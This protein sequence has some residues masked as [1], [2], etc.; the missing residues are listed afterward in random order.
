VSTRWDGPRTRQVGLL[1][2]AVAW[3]AWSCTTIAGLDGDYQLGSGV[4]GSAQAVGGAN[5]RASSGGASST[6]SDTGGESRGS[7]G[8]GGSG[9][10]GGMNPPVCGDG[11]I[12]P[13]EECDD[14]PSS[15]SQYCDACDVI[16]DGP[17]EVED[18]QSHHCYYDTVADAMHNSWQTGRSWCQTAFNG[19]LVVISDM[20][21]LAFVQ[22]LASNEYNEDRWIGATDSGQEGQY[23][24]VNGEPWVYMNGNAPWASGEPSQ[25][26][27]DDCIVLQWDGSI[28]EVSC[29]QGGTHQM[30]ERVPEGS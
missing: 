25:S 7:A 16:C 17:F 12:D 23:E 18:P 15:P 27:T 30:C 4:G 26:T 2:P 10:S 5:S 8:G 29:V 21:E 22:G 13:G 3:I 9:G 11:H 28:A 24:W 14:G 6:S 19:D 1:V 20:A